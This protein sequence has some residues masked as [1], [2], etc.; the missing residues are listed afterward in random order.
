MAG[1]LVKS[2]EMAVTREKTSSTKL[3][4]KT[5]MLDFQNCL[6]KDSQIVNICAPIIWEHTNYIEVKMSE[7]I[8]W[9]RALYMK[10]YSC[11][12]GWKSCVGNGLWIVQCEI[13]ALKCNFYFEHKANVPRNVW[14]HPQNYLAELFWKTMFVETVL[15]YKDKKVE[16]MPQF[17]WCFCDTRS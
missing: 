17:C 16:E 7:A 13:V 12:A 9:G 5:N 1:G 2:L 8:F 10:P 15:L 3:Q 11:G 14:F 4:W 6:V